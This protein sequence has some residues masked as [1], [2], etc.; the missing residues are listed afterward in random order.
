MMTQACVNVAPS[1][2]VDAGTYKKTISSKNL[3][4]GTYY[5][6]FEMKNYTETKKITV[7]R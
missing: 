5:V 1:N 4:R 3:R 6:T 7:T 2:M